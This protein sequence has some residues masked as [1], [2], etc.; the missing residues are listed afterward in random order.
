M[1]AVAILNKLAVELDV[2]KATENVRSFVL[3]LLGCESV[4]LF[5]L[6]HETKML[7]QAQAITKESALKLLLHDNF[8]RIHLPLA[9]ELSCV[10]L[11]LSGS[12]C[13]GVSDQLF[14]GMA[15]IEIPV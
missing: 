9:F 5:L 13:L 10:A 15:V 7:R 12:C 3:E 11:I 2:Y 4:T 14:H 6:D 8:A 1:Q